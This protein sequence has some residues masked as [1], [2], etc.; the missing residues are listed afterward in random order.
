VQFDEHHDEQPGLPGRK[1]SPKLQAK[2]R[3]AVIQK[4]WKQFSISKWA[5]AHPLLCL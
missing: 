2:R 1:P 3:Q 4:M 5:R